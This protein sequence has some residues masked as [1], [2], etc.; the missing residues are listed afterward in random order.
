MIDLEE[1]I[2]EVQ[3]STEIKDKMWSTEE[4]STDYDVWAEYMPD[5]TM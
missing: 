4:I 2:Q 3:E 5:V 1:E